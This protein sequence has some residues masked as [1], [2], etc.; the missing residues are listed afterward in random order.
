MVTAR[1]DPDSM[2]FMHR[3]LGRSVGVVLGGGGA[4]GCSHLS[5]VR[6]LENE[7]IPID[8]IAG[9]SIGAFMG[10]LYAWKTDNLYMIPVVA[11]F[12]AEMSS[13][14]KKIRDLTFPI[15]SYFT[16]LAFN[17]SIVKLFQGKKIEDLWLPFFCMSTDLT[18]SKAIPH[19]NGALWRYVRASMTLVNFMPPIC[20]VIMD[21]DNPNSKRVHYLADGGYMNNLPVDIMREMIGPKGTIIAAD[22]QSDWTFAGDDY[23]D[24]LNG[25]WYLYKWLNPWGKTPKIPTSSDIQTQLAYISSVQV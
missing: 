19:R 18:D 8:F 11:K 21:D 4:R 2:N 7:G 12:S 22:V 9:S 17:R 15:T 3:L 6:A 10:G 5:V 13:T 14:W 20:D 24:Y 25:W 16:G 1:S 23:G